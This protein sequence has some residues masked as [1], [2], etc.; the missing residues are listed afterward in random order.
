MTT[1]NLNGLPQ[2]CGLTSKAKHETA[3]AAQHSLWEPPWF[4]T[5]YL[6]E[7]LKVQSYALVLFE[8]CLHMTH[9][10][11]CLSMAFKSGFFVESASQRY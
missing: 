4:S 9:N 8:N 1:Q 3:S 7:F 11:A 6:V 2:M 5:H 10:E